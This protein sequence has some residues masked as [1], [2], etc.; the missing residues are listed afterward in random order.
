MFA[1]YVSRYTKIGQWMSTEV[2]SFS[3][4]TADEVNQLFRWELNSPMAFDGVAFSHRDWRVKFLYTPS[5]SPACLGVWELL[6]AI[7]YTNVLDLHEYALTLHNMYSFG[8][9]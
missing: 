5:T 7:P 3:I 2:K 6:V 9:K 4:E 1:V 8:A